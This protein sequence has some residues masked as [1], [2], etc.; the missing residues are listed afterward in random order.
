MDPTQQVQEHGGPGQ[1][2]FPI[3]AEACVVGRGEGIPQVSL[4]AGEMAQGKGTCSVSCLHQFESLAPQS[5]TDFQGPLPSRARNSP[6][7]PLGVALTF[8]PEK[9]VRFGRVGSVCCS[10]LTPVPVVRDHSCRAQG[11]LHSARDQTWIH[12]M[13]GKCPIPGTISLTE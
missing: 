9:K 5:P 10:E 2:R 7:V 8:P 4:W 13:Q 12:R 6:S 11:N 1:A 3:P